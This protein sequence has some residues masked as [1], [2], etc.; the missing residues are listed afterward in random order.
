M[1]LK[2]FFPPATMSQNKTVY[3]WSQP[4]QKIQI[5][6]FN[7]FCSN[8][9]F[10]TRNF[11][12]WRKTNYRNKLFVKPNLSPQRKLKMILKLVRLLQGREGSLLDA[13]KAT[14]ELY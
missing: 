12:M 6:R 10:R 13:Q 5:P 11:A 7:I 3:P 14:K 1:F 4:E 9:K 8:L 2:P